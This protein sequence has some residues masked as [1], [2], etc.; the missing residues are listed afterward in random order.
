MD[1]LQTRGVDKRRV[2]ADGVRVTSCTFNRAMA[3][4]SERQA[5]GLRNSRYSRWWDKLSETEKHV[6]RDRSSACMRKLR[7]AR[8]ELSAHRLGIASAQPEGFI[9]QSLNAVPGTGTQLDTS[10]PRS[11]GSD[12][13]RVLQCR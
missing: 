8:S 7:Q 12:E 11:S 6:R 10:A 2:L 3:A 1:L 5:V 13:Q 4:V 9:E